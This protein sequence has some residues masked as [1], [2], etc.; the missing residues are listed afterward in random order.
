VAAAACHSVAEQLFEQQL[1][2]IDVKEPVLMVGGTSLI[3][4]LP[5]AVEELLKVKVIVPENAQYIGAVG[6]ALLASGFI[7]K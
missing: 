3:E 5:K 1:Q 2:E 4:G 6:A 7:S